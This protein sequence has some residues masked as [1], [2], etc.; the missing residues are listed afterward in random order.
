MTAKEIENANEFFQIALENYNDVVKGKYYNK[1]TEACRSK[2]ELA[3]EAV[4]KAILVCCGKYADKIN[5]NEDFT[6]SE[7]VKWLVSVGIIP[8]NPNDPE[9]PGPIQWMF[10]HVRRARNDVG[11]HVHLEEDITHIH[12]NY[13]L[14]LETDV[15]IE[16][17]R[18]LINRYIAGND[19]YIFELQTTANQI[20][21]EEAYRAK[22]NVYHTAGYVGLGVTQDHFD[23]FNNAFA[24]LTNPKKEEKSR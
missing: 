11:G 15:L 21:I 6:Q 3:L 4:V 24:E 17:G 1:D 23:A 13:E 20:E 16:W 12:D 18:S 19:Y 14:V 2:C 5:K 10:D 7:D 9:K 8:P 22:T